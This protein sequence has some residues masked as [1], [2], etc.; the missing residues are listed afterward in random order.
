[1]IVTTAA[2]PDILSLTPPACQQDRHDIGTVPPT[3]A[4]P[5]GAGSDTPLDPGIR[6]PGGMPTRT[7]AWDRRGHPCPRGP[8]P[9]NLERP[10]ADRRRVASG[11]LRAA[12]TRAFGAWQEPLVDQLSHHLRV[13]HVRLMADRGQDHRL[14]PGQRGLEHLEVAARDDPVLV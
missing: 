13:R 6:E 14:S 9:A 3:A 12:S 7:W 10:A 5:A 8:G 11:A 4:S 2:N 1:D